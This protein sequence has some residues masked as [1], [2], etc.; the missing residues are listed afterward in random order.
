MSTTKTEVRTALL[1]LLKGTE[2]DWATSAEDNVSTNSTES[3]DSLPAI[4]IQDAPETAQKRDVSST[5]YIRDWQIRIELTVES[6]VGY[7]EDLDDL[8]KEVHDLIMANQRL[9]GKA[10]GITYTGSEPLY[11][12]AGQKVIGKLVLNYTIKYFY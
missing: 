2:P 6:N 7:D 9:S 1:T 11:D 5:S 3:L 10:I 4:E 8:E 12:H